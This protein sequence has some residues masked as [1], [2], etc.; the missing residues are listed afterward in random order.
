MPIRQEKSKLF[1]D[2][3]SFAPEVLT[4]VWEWIDSFDY[5][6]LRPR[7]A[8][9]LE[10]GD[11]TFHLAEYAFRDKIYSVAKCSD[12]RELIGSIMGVADQS[13]PSE[14]RTIVGSFMD[15]LARRVA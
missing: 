2:T 13:R 8:A 1:D 12:G 10:K 11:L 7:D 6:P 14:G 3:R 15:L 5:Q 4:A 9:T